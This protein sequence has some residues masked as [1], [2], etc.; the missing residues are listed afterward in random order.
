MISPEIWIIL[1]KNSQYSTYLDVIRLG[2]Y[3][4]RIEKYSAS[5]SCFRKILPE[6][7]LSTQCACSFCHEVCTQ[8]ATWPM[9]H[10]RIKVS[11]KPSEFL[12]YVSLWKDAPLACSQVTICI[13]GNARKLFHQMK[14]EYDHLNVCSSCVLILFMTSCE[15]C[16]AWIECAA[17]AQNKQTL[18]EG[19]IPTAIY[20]NI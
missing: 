4:I 5:Y 15:W 14:K 6:E 19:L 17:P 7:P 9:V 13:F 20:R 3:P 16:Q 10:L 18:N 1:S 12:K 8:H 11:T 2:F